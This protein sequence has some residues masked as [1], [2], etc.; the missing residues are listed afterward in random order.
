[1]GHPVRKGERGEGGGTSSEASEASEGASRRGSCST[2][3]WPGPAV[4]SEFY[5]ARHNPETNCP[6]WEPAI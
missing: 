4:Y 6:T 1:M 3:K 5:V 2:C